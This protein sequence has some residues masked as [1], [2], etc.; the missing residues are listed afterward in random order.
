MA[1]WLLATMSTE[2][3]SEP[4]CPLH[5]KHPAG[6]R[7]QVLPRAQAP[8][9][10]EQ[11][12]WA[13]YHAKNALLIGSHADYLVLDLTDND[14]LTCNINHQPFI[15]C[16]YWGAW[17]SGDE[18]GGRMCLKIHVEPGHLVGHRCGLGWGTWVNNQVRG[19]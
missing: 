11:R 16:Q 19:D 14:D 8:T 3:N 17:L 18:G 4:T 5:C 15:C 13:S 12:Q 10:R 6:G 1:D 9:T 2:D 7:L